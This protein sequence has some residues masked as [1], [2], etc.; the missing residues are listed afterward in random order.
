M[1]DEVSFQLRIEPVG[2][3]GIRQAVVGLSVG[4]DVYPT[5][6]FQPTTFRSTISSRLLQDLAGRGMLNP[7]TGP[8]FIVR[9]LRIAQQPVPDLRVSV[10]LAANVFDIDGI[11]GANFLQPFSELRLDIPTLRVKLIP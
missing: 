5:M 6:V 8:T 1:P 7:S 9:D 3:R 10:G 2:S 11:L 4:P